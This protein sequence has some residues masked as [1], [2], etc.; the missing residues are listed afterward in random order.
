MMKPTVVKR[1]MRPVKEAV[2]RKNGVLLAADEAVPEW[3]SVGTSA[4]REGKSLSGG[5]QGRKG[6]VGHTH[7]LWL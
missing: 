5:E 4:S 6:G 2:R 7:R 1:R 3:E